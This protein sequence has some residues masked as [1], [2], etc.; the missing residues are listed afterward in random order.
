MER[1][2]VSK[3]IYVLNVEKV[4]KVVDEKNNLKRKF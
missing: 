4:F 3:D 2:V 1:D